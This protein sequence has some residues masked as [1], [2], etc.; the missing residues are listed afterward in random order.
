FLDAYTLTFAALLFTFGVLGDRYGRKPALL[1][2]ITVFG[3]ASALSAYAVGPGMLIGTRALMAVGGAA[4]LPSTLSI[5][6]Y[7][8]DADERGKAIGIWA[9]VSGL[10]IAIGPITG[11]ALL[12]RFWWGSVFLVNV[13]LVV[14]GLF[15]VWRLVP[16]SKDPDPQRLDPAGV[17][18]SIVGLVALVFGIIR[19][20]ENGSFTDPV[21]VGSFVGGLVVLG[22][23]WL[24]ERRSDH[25]ALDVGLFRNRAFSAASAAVTLAFFALFGVTFFL[26]FYLQ[27]ARAYS[28]FQAGLRLLPVAIAVAVFSPLSSRLVRRFGAKLVAS[29]GLSVVVVAFLL[30]TQ[31]QVSSSIWFLEGILFLQGTGLAN[32]IAPSTTSIQL[33]LPRERAGAGSAVNNTTRQ[34]GG[35]L[36]IAILGSILSATYSSGLL[37]SLPDA[38]PAAARQAAGQSLG[39]ALEVARQLPP[40][41][42][43][44]LA[45]PAR[46]AFMHALHVTALAAAGVAALGA[47]VVAVWLPGRPDGGDGGSADGATDTSDTT[48]TTGSGDR[49]GERTVDL[50]GPRQGAGRHRRE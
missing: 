19:A 9:G 20:G 32:T 25:P 35:A 26:T 12:E 31:L 11:G 6:N 44:A 1:L 5:I 30:Y 34:I 33:V 49:T 4:V 42:G 18:L 27:F 15:L 29:T 14:V 45:D 8:F 22:V 39:A 10:A 50:R 16:D 7:V 17:L 3:I 24:L 36:G 41:L 46:T 40:Q 21:A 47:L 2:G 43:A 28:P 38:L 48:D 37:G 23:F 13:P